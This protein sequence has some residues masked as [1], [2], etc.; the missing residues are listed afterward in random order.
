[1]VIEEN[2]LLAYFP[3]IGKLFQMLIC[4]V[5]KSFYCTR[6]STIGIYENR[7]IKFF[8]KLFAFRKRQNVGNEV[9]KVQVLSDDQ[10]K[11]FLIEAQEEEYLLTKV[12]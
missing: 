7:D 12:C 3:V 11:K 6:R 1:M 4:E 5:F 8:L 2:V 10:F 9:K